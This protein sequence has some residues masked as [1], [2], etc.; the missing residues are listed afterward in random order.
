MALVSLKMKKTK[1]RI[2]YLAALLIVT[3]IT[4]IV[5]ALGNSAENSVTGLNLVFNE[6][7]LSLIGFTIILAF[8]G[9]K[10]FN[11]L[12]IPQIV[13][14][15]ATGVVLG[16][17]LLNLIPLRLSSELLFVSEIAL[18]LIGFDIGSHLQLDEIRRYGRSILSILV[19]EAIGA[20]AL[21]AFGVYL[22]TRDMNA[23][24]IFGAISTATAPA[25]TVDVLAEY[26]AKG[27]MTTNLLAVIGLDDAVALLLFSLCSGIV[28]NNL[29][30]S[31]STPILSILMVPVVEIGGSLFL[32][33]VISLT[34]DILLHRIKGQHDGMAI[35]IGFVLLSVGVSVTLGMSLILTTMTVGFV[36]INRSPEHGYRIRYTVEQA[37]PILYVL[38]FALIGA[39]FQIQ[40]LPTMGVLG[41]IYVTLRTL[42]K[43][44]GAR[45]GG[46]L[47]G[48]EPRV[49][50]NLG[51]GLLSQAGVAVGL[52]ID[53][54]TRFLS[55]GPSGEALGALIINV[56]T[57]ST[58]IVQI[59][60]P[61]CVKLAITRAGE[62]GKGRGTMDEWASETAD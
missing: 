1:Q 62:I 13:G 21:V 50:S 38:F 20:F 15:I 26:S 7:T 24:L 5:T 18:G 44:T 33:V 25:A 37:G 14:F 2:G 22:F 35:S 17:S 47:G 36:L 29:T 48:A 57:A 58:F 53:T 9:S 49:Y 8:I 60:G 28:E 31:A 19:L 6:N 45:I 32:G 10:L 43:Y 54:A 61:I 3:L 27:P 11:R 4:D 59:I 42:G 51:L 46:Q 16:P 52:A 56:I 30:Q 40:L 39:R 34:L 12:G 55:Y 41:L 23:A